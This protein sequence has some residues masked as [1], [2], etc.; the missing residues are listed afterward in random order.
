MVLEE[1]DMQGC[2]IK[3]TWF[4][5]AFATLDVNTSNE[6]IAHYTHAY[7]LRLLDGYLMPN[8]STFKVS[9]K[10]LPFLRDFGEAERV[11]WGSAV[12]ATP[13]H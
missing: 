1:T 2:T 3:L 12:L 13:N 5:S 10:W 11:N 4:R 9:L 6:T 8:A 7:I